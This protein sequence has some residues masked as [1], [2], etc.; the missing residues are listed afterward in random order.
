M[1]INLLNRFLNNDCSDLEK[2][3]VEAWLLNPNN[4]ELISKWMAKHWDNTNSIE[5]T[6]NENLNYTKIRAIIQARIGL[7]RNSDRKN[8]K[9]V[10]LDFI[11]NNKPLR[12]VAAAVIIFSFITNLYFLFSSN[13]NAE[14]GIT[15][16]EKRVGPLD[17][18]PPKSTNAV[19]TLANG[20]KIQLDSVGK[21]ILA[22]EGTVKVAKNELGEIV[23]SESAKTNSISY[24]TMSLPKGSKPMRLVLSDGSLVWLN[25]ASSV[26]FPTAFIGS[27][28][29]VSITGEA[30]FEVAHNASKPF[31]VS[32]DDITVRVLGTHFNV[33]TYQ[34]ES[35][36]KV[37]LLEGSVNVLKGNNTARLKP[38]E[39]VVVTKDKISLIT[40]I[41]LEEVMSWKNGQFYFKGTELKS[42]MRQIEKYYNVEVEFK[43]DINYE[44]YAKMDRNINVSEFLKKLELTNLVHF[45]IEGNKITVMK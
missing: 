44:F 28:R 18:A 42:I 10:I 39:Q 13:R 21:G 22:T 25:A 23:Y 6:T 19:L 1:D 4:D 40:N 3:E 30:Y 33:N 8:A 31:Y 15:G 14:R 17:I 12:Y 2:Q 32:H 24:N 43:D 36:I 11:K 26:T 34:D 41:D 5:N 9:V 7:H 45:K 35:N 37:T 27:E 20:Q 16:I 38:G 29:K